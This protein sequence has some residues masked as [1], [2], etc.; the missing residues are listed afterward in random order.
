MHVADLIVNSLRLGTSGTRWVPVLDD[1][2]WRLTG[3]DIERLPTILEA[4]I[5]ATRDVI[6]AFMEA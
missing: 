6:S 1:G 2:A 4:T 3:L 5:T